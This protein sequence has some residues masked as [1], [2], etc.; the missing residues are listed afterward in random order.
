MIPPLFSHSAMSARHLLARGAIAACAPIRDCAGRKGA[1]LRRSVS[2]GEK[3]KAES[4]TPGPC[5]VAFGSFGGT[6]VFSAATIGER[7]GTLEI[8]VFIIPRQPRPVNPPTPAIS[9]YYESLLVL[10][11]NLYYNRGTSETPVG[12]DP[13]DC[14]RCMTHRHRRPSCPFDLCARRGPTA[15]RQP[16]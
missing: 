1:C 13:R 15:R 16:R 2:H 11:C 5:Q 7:C 9:H 3:H 12:G 8:Y 14:Q 6:A 10:L 4:K